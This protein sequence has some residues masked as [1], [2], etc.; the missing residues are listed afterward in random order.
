MHNK[1][2]YFVYQY[3]DTKIYKDADVY[4]KH[5]PITITYAR[6]KGKKGNTGGGAE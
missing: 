3:Y 5:P 6:K 4:A 2:M 1:I